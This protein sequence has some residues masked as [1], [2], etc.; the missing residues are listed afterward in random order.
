MGKNA[1]SGPSIMTL[2]QI[3]TSYNYLP[4]KWPWHR[5]IYNLWNLFT[6]LS[7]LLTTLVS[8]ITYVLYML[9]YAST[10]VFSICRY[11]IYTEQ[12]NPTLF[13]R[14]E[15]FNSC[16]HVKIIFLSAGIP[17]N[18]KKYLWNYKQY[19]NELMYR[20]SKF[21]YEHRGTM[22]TTPWHDNVK[23]FSS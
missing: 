8:V 2:T 10:T 19:T 11:Q 9:W 7:S 12:I 6:I 3:S 18:T 4:S 20:H 23:L 1:V 15:F 22:R 21:H 17:I 14:L 5:T 16:G 13:C